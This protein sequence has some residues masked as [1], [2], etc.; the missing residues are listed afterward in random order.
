MLERKF[1]EPRLAV[2]SERVTVEGASES[3]VV[4]RLRVDLDADRPDEPCDDT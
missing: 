1:D 2:M 3:S 4:P